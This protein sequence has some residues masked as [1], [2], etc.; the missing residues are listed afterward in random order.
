MVHVLFHAIDLHITNIM[1]MKICLRF[2][3]L[4]V[5]LLNAQF[6]MLMMVIPNRAQ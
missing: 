2:I 4:D 6:L 1:I 5:I 3:A